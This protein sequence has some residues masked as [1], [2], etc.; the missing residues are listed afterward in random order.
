VYQM[1]GKRIVAQINMQTTLRSSA[2][3]FSRD[4]KYLMIIG[5]VPDFKISIYD[6]KAQQFL[7]IPN[8]K[9]PFGFNKLRNV[10]FNPRSN[11]EFCILSDTMIYFYTLKAAFQSGDKYI[12]D[13]DDENRVLELVDSYRLDLAT[14]SNTDV[15]NNLDTPV[16]FHSLKWDMYSRVHVCTNLTQMLQITSINPHVEQAME[17][18]SI[19][20][21]TLM[22]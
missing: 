7:A 15:V 8:T 6:L 13:E 18:G 11:N 21:T 4:G 17:I 1:P 19:P 14:F 2:M 22:T 9:L 12:G 10:A 5:G 16:E 3:A 20:H